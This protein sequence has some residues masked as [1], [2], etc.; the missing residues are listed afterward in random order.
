MPTTYIM[1][2]SKLGQ[3]E[4][5]A[6]AIAQLLQQMGSRVQRINVLVDALPNVQPNDFVVLGMPVYYG[7]HY[8]RALEVIAPYLSEKYRQRLALFSVN[9]TARKS[10][11][12]SVNNNPYFLKLCS[13]LG[14]KPRIAGVFAGQLN[15]SAYR[16]IDRLMIRFIMFMTGGNTNQ[17]CAEQYTDWQQVSAFS[18]QIFK[19]SQ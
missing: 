3:T 8:N 16:W 1:Y 14:F 19:E 10:E 18:Q 13:Q 6:T 9:L 15:Y 17:Q 4:L 2:A 11:K 12:C 5:I 7:K